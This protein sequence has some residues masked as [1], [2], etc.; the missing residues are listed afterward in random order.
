MTNSP[1]GL[2]SFVEFIDLSFRRPHLQTPA[3]CAIRTL[4]TS[5][6]SPSDAIA[7]PSLDGAPKQ[8]S[9]KIQQLVHDIASLTLLEVSDLNDLLKVKLEG[10]LKDLLR[11]NETEREIIHIV[12]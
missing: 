6:V 7:T 9:P 3:L 4:K 2:E 1:L 10:K 12:C 5:P 11:E 8:Y